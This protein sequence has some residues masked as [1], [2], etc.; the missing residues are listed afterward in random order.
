[1]MQR[2]TYEHLKAAILSKLCPDTEEDKIVTPECLLRRQLHD[3]ESIYELVR[4]LEKLL[5][6]ATPGL[7]A[8]VNIQGC[9]FTL[10]I[11]YHSK[12]YSS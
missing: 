5:N 6:L 11:H 9:V 8:A 1:M 3:G 2:Q 10:S 12:Y 4:D 7:P